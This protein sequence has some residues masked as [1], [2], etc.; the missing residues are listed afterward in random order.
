MSSKRER[1]YEETKSDAK[2]SLSA[3]SS[4]SSVS[5]PAAASSASS[6]AASSA[7]SSAS[8]AASSAASDA[9]A[10][11]SI[12]NQVTAEVDRKVRKAFEKWTPRDLNEVMTITQTD[13]SIKLFGISPIE[14]WKKEVATVRLIWEI[15]QA[16]EACKKFA[17]KDAS[18]NTI[19]RSC[20]ICGFGLGSAPKKNGLNPECEHVMPVAQAV[21]FRNMYNTCTYNPNNEAL[22]NYYRA[23]YKWSHEICN[24]VKS[25]TNFITVK[26]G[27]LVPD[28]E[29]INE[30]LDNLTTSMRRGRVQLMKTIIDRGGGVQTWRA[31]RINEIK[32]V[33]K[34]LISTLGE[35]NEGEFLTRCVANATNVPWKQSPSPDKNLLLRI[36]FPER[37][38]NV[39]TKATEYIKEP[40][41]EAYYQT[42]L[43]V[44]LKIYWALV[45]TQEF[46]VKHAPS[47]PPSSPPKKP[48]TGSLSS[49]SS[50]SITESQYELSA[51]SPVSSQAPRSDGEPTLEQIRRA[52][53]QR[54][55]YPDAEPTP[56]PTPFLQRGNNMKIYGDIIR[57][58]LHLKQ[59]YTIDLNWL[60]QYLEIKSKEFGGF[61]TTYN[62]KP[63]DSTV[64]AITDLTFKLYKEWKYDLGELNPPGNTRFNK[65]IENRIDNLEPQG[66]KPTIGARRT[67]RRKKKH[68]RRT[69]RKRRHQ[70]IKMSSMRHSLS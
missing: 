70:S 56:L 32:R 3:S 54:P 49:P 13:L 48:R 55:D 62:S 12:E 27:E 10:N 14:I 42:I 67:Y 52:N 40:A 63:N 26:D 66:V 24:Q 21:L 57:K 29:V 23:E 61:E 31:N 43:F 35:V 11:E 46:E 59:D 16:S 17:D 58:L 9:A 53:E 36:L 45:D 22:N 18:G 6:S 60:D 69:Y 7:A 38:E 34:Q 20:W 15:T 64:T 33:C 30:Y 2:R 19:P 47:T 5:D 4:A 8:S 44:Y 37:K 1:L 65:P 41:D 68:L 51:F 28:D 50:R 25:H 39:P